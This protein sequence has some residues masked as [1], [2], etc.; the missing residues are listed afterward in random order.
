MLAILLAL[1]QVAQPQ[2]A[3]ES[4]AQPTLEGLALEGAPIALVRIERLHRVRHLSPGIDRRAWPEDPIRFAEALVEQR[5][6]GSPGEERVFFLFTV[7]GPA[8][9][10]AADALVEG[11]RALVFLEPRQR[12]AT[13]VSRV[14]AKRLAILAGA[15]GPRTPLQ[16]GIWRTEAR[17]GKLFA[18]IPATFGVLPEALA[19]HVVEGALPLERLL[20]W[21]DEELDRVTPQ[22][23]A[24]LHSTGATPWWVEVAADG[25]FRDA[26]QQ[27]KLDSDQLAAFWRT[28][29]QERFCELSDSVGWSRAPD[30]GAFVVSIRRRDGFHLVRI[31]PASTD[32]LDTQESTDQMVRARCILD[33]FPGEERPKLER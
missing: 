31:W 6:L 1:L 25:T 18:R 28:V 5:L 15:E 16:G 20:A 8:E 4:R 10:S 23:R 32:L 2:V 21:L 9:G 24:E 7:G 3:A 11:D 33:A 14:T 19:P 13:R 29:D 17:E 30:D 26:K 12:L 22:A 27:G